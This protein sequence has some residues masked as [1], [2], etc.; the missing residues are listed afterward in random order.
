MI[1]AGCRRERAGSGEDWDMRHLLLCFVSAL[2]L[3][4]GCQRDVSGKYIGKFTNGVWWLQLVRTPDNHLTGQLEASVLKA[5][6]SIERETVSLTGAVNGAN[7]TISAKQLGFDV[8]TL[9]GTL[10]GDTL[11]LTG[12]QPSPI[13]LT[14]S[15]LGDYQQ[16][17]NALNAQ[18]QRI[19]AAKNAAVARQRTEQTQQ[20]F[21]SEI[22]R[23]VGGM[24]RFDSEADVYLSRFPESNSATTRS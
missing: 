14:Q 23:I 6:G 8:L 20:N 7:V 22:D 24:Q 12:G 9:S 10:D 15:D 2:V 17:L 1:A 13:V 3:L 4:S 19:L 21:I 18:S 16:Q 5:D 11:T